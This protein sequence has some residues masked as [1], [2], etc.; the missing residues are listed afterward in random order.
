[1]VMLPLKPGR[2]VQTVLPSEATLTTGP[3]LWL[4]TM[5]GCMTLLQ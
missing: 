2:S 1:M 3:G 4:G 5:S